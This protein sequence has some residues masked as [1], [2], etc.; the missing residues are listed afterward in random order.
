MT[1]QRGVRISAVTRLMGRRDMLVAA[2][3]TWL[4]V[5][6]IRRVIVVDWGCKEDLAEVKRARDP[7]VWII[8]VPG[9]MYWRQGEPWNIGDRF[10]DEGWILNIDCDVTIADRRFVERLD[11]DDHSGFHTC[12]REGH[13]LTGTCLITKEQYLAVNGYA[14]GLSGYGSEDLDIYARLE[15][16]FARRRDLITGKAG[17]VPMFE[18]IPHGTERRIENTDLL[19]GRGNESSSEA[20]ILEDPHLRQKRVERA[21]TAACERNKAHMRTVSPEVQGR[22]RFHAVVWHLGEESHALV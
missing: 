11:F 2:L 12:D 20:D 17:G 22:C 9:Q 3:P 5:Q 19:P 18:H 13:S 4:E 16:R 6:E 1:L 21:F 10:A 15:R 14:E 7:R 8:H